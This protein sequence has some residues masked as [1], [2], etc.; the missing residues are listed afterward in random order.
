MADEKFEFCKNCYEKYGTEL[1]DHMDVLRAAFD[2][3]K[4]C[5]F[6]RYPD[7]NTDVLRRHMEMCEP[8]GVKGLS[9]H[10]CKRRQLWR[11]IHSDLHDEIMKFRKIPHEHKQL[12]KMTYEESDDE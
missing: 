2:D 12:L 11:N 6:K 9:F 8:F 4:R 7:T 1:P 5:Y 3:W 10:Q